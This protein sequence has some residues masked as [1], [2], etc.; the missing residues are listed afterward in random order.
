MHFQHLM[1][2]SNNLMHVCVSVSLSQLCIPDTQECERSQTKLEARGR[3][4]STTRLTQKGR[5][6]H[7]GITRNLED[8]E[9]ALQ[10]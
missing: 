7:S 3:H 10:H 2:H 5:R 9:Q 4:V 1:L 8:V 6:Q